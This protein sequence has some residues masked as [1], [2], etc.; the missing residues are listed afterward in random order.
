M[1]S[2]FRWILILT[3]PALLY[4]L[5]KSPLPPQRNSRRVEFN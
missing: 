2:L 5:Y 1:L 4:W 3:V